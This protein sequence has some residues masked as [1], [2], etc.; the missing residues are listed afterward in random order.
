[1]E[2]AD[3]KQIITQ[4]ILTMN[5]LHMKRNRIVGEYLLHFLLLELCIFVK[6]SD[7]YPSTCVMIKPKWTKFTIT[8]KSGS[9]I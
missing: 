5:I 8:S 9:K 6:I 3:F 7:K 4:K 2:E 1:M